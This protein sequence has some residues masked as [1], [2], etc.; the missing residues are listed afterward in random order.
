MS[1]KIIADAKYASEILELV[2]NDEEPSKHLKARL[3][4]LGLHIQERRPDGQTIIWE[5]AV[6]P[7][8]IATADTRAD[9][10]QA[11]Q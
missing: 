6:P 3:E 7:G 4:A 11:L 5:C 2:F 8:D 10:E 9:V 1:T